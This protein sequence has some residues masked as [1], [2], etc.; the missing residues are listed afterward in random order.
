MTWKRL[1]RNQTTWKRQKGKKCRTLDCNH[2][3][4]IKGYCVNCYNNEKYRRMKNEQERD[5][6]KNTTVQ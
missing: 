5:N 3:A 4:R 1:S 2:N 6:L